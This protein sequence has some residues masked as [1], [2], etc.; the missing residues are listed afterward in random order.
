MQPKAVSKFDQA[1][2]AAASVM[3]TNPNSGRSHFFDIPSCR[4]RLG[5]TLHT[6]ESASQ[7]RFLDSMACKSSTSQVGN[8]STRDFTP[9]KD[10]SW[11]IIPE[12]S[13]Q[14]TF[15]AVVPRPH[16]ALRGGSGKPSKLAA[17][18]ASRRLAEP[19]KEDSQIR[20]NSPQSNTSPSAIS[21]LD[22]LSL[23]ETKPWSA[24]SPSLASRLGS[25]KRQR[26]EES[27]S[28]MTATTIS[29]DKRDGSSSES[30]QKEPRLTAEEALQEQPQLTT[31]ASAFA[32]ALCGKHSITHQVD[33]LSSMSETLHMTNLREENGFSGPSP[34]DIVTQAQAK[35]RTT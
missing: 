4:M 16:L 21:L 28:S 12:Q 15:T 35:G 8:G 31:Q 6:G 10:I 13:R 30:P 3:P 24:S 22:K 11:S 1:V 19:K 29:R 2:N 32:S 27:K 33:I 34:D 23:K 5:H 18:A 25:A 17:L 26:E 7:P 14:A 20:T 9:F